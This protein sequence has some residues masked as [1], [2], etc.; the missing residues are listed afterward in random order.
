M[1]LGIEKESLILAA[2]LC[3]SEMA[4]IMKCICGCNLVLNMRSNLYD[5]CNKTLNILRKSCDIIERFLN[6]VL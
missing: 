1:R 6:F 5:T 2:I 3:R 4:G